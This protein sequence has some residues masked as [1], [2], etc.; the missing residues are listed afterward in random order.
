MIGATAGWKPEHDAGLALD[1]L[2]AVGVHQQRERHPVGAGRGLHDVGEVAL[3]RRLV[4]VLQLLAGVLL[5]P[6]EVEVAAVVDALDL[7][8]AERELV[9]DVER[10]AGVVGQLVRAVLVPAQPAPG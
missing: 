1:L 8:P 9:L 4:E 5:V 3:V 7:L 2:L 10:R 6:A